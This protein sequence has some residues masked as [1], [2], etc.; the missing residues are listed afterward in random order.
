MRALA[1]LAGDHAAVERVPGELDQ[2]I[3]Q[4]LLARPFVVL[5][6][7][8]SQ[9]LQRIADGGAAH[10]VEDTFQEEAAILEAAHGELALLHRA[11][12]VLGKPVRISRVSLVLAGLA[13][14]ADGELEALGK[15]PAFIERP[16]SLGDG[17]TGSSD[18]RQVAEA[19]AALLN[20]CR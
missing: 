8:A 12:L 17:L 6:A 9:R 14:L 7:L 13:E 2:G 11:S 3:R 16:R 1:A 19:D 4:P 5:A 15:E 18:Q 10:R 20:R